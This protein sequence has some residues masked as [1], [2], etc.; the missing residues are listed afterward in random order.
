VISPPTNTPGRSADRIEDLVRL[1]QPPARVW[2][3]LTEPAELSAW[4]G[5][6]L[7]GATIA[8]GAHVT[9]R[10][11]IPGHEQFTFDVTIEEMD[12]ERRFTWR[13]HPGAADP[14]ADF[15]AEPRTLVT[16]TL[17]GTPD[18]GTLLRVVESGFEGLAAARRTA[19]LLGNT[20]GWTTQLHERLPGYLASAA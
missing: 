18:G 15:S 5:A 17:E 2:R 12:A 11:T 6:G 20:K 8:P 16:F 13:W 1:P 3:A 10:F 4:F 14:S 19:A 7:T 9:G